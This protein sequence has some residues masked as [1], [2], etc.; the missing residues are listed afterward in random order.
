[1]SELV[2]SKSSGVLNTLKPTITATVVSPYKVNKNHSFRTSGYKQTSSQ[3]ELYNGDYHVV[4]GSQMQS[5]EEAIADA[6]V[7]NMQGCSLLYI[8][9]QRKLL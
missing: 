1:M 4:S 7:S 2:E 5:C 3:P 8:Q 6:V 9:N